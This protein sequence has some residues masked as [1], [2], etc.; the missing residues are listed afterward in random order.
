MLA[1]VQFSVLLWLFSV[2][3]GVFSDYLEKA[4]CRPVGRYCYSIYIMQNLS[5]YMSLH[6]IWSHKS[7]CSDHCVLAVLFAFVIS[8]LLGIITYH[9]IEVPSYNFLSSIFVNKR[10]QRER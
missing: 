9:L 5:F 1:I 4:L 8:I 6:L 2:R 3:K 10:C 7:F